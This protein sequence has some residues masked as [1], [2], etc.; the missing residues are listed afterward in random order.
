WEQARPGAN[1]N[2]MGN[3]EDAAKV[4]KVM[5]SEKWMLEHINSPFL[6]LIWSSETPVGSV[7]ARECGASVTFELTDPPHSRASPLPQG[8][9]TLLKNAGNPHR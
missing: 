3:R 2:D 9:S 4:P 7:L 6:S 5:E 8:I 1:A